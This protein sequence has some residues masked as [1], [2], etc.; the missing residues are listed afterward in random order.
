V[1]RETQPVRVAA[2]ATAVP[3]TTITQTE[4]EQGLRRYYG[5][6]LS[7]RSQSILQKIFQH[8]GIRTRRLA[9]DRPERMVEETPDER[10]GR[11]TDYAVRLSAEACRKALAR[12]GAP[13]TAVRALVVNTCTGY[14]CPGVSTYV[15]EA[16]GLSPETR[17]YDLVGAGCGGAIPNLEIAGGLLDGDPGVVL[18]VSVEICTATFQM[19]DDLSLIISNALFGDGASATVLW[20][21]PEGLR[22]V[23]SARL[24]APQYREDIRYVYR[25]GQLHNQIS[26][27]L[28]EI[29]RPLVGRVVA[30]L[31]ER[32]GLA[33]ADIRHWA[34][35]P[36]GEK[37]LSA[38]QEELRLP[39]ERVQVAREIMEAYGNMSSPTVWFEMERILAAGIDPD[40]WCVMLA[41]GAGLSVHACLLQA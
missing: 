26:M 14:L 37:I 21:R 36:G 31:L 8:P 29:L 9:I 40:D 3:D 7:P 11:F 35:H 24:Y 10:I 19:G 5:H 17:V 28:P 15:L 16:L 32:H 6:L 20:R 39:P 12:A 4:C 23:D 33:P 38:L 25:Q 1:P 18:S 30:G 34:I 27:R 2:V 41:M 22:V 13:P